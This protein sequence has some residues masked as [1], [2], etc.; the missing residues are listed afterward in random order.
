MTWLGTPGY[1]SPTSDLY[2]GFWLDLFWWSEQRNSVWV[3]YRFPEKWATIRVPL[4]WRSALP[5]RLRTRL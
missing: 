3:W 2:L 1:R 4:V 5:A